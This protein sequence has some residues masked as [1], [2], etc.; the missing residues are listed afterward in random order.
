MADDDS[1]TPDTTESSES[2]SDEEV[3]AC[4]EGR[5]CTVRVKMNEGQY[6]WV[7]TAQQ[8]YEVNDY[9]T[10]EHIVHLV[11]MDTHKKVYHIAHGPDNTQY[12]PFD[13]QYTMMDFESSLDLKKNHFHVLFIMYI[14]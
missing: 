10:L 14:Q 3:I 6:D 9:D 13:Y 5:T 2:V 1:F 12:T 11:E 7:T 4:E 8:T